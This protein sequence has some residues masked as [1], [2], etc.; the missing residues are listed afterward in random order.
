[1][2]Q[3]ITGMPGLASSQSPHASSNASSKP[4]AHNWPATWRGVVGIIVPWNY[5]LYL[6][7]GPL[8]GA[9]AAG[10]RVMLK[11]SEFTPAC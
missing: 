4:S 11:L 6:A 3:A 7:I 9:L 8:V 10:N 1:M 2:P 5:P